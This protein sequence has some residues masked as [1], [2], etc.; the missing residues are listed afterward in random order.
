MK[1][2]FDCDIDGK[3]F[4]LE[5]EGIAEEIRLVSEPF[6]DAVTKALEFQLEA[7]VKDRK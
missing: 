1:L 3:K 6:A 4:N 7:M 5:V 2:K